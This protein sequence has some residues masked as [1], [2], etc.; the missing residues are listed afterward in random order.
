MAE[1]SEIEGFVPLPPPTSNGAA[2]AKERKKPGPRKGWKRS[3]LVSLDASDPAQH[4]QSSTPPHGT[5]VLHHSVAAC[6]TC[7]QE[8]P[9]LT[10]AVVRELV[11]SS[12]DRIEAVGSSAE[13]VAVSDIRYLAARLNGYCSLGCWR[14][15]EDAR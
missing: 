6:P 9:Q 5:A 10:L 3:A 11:Q 4:R 2:D 1:G 7:D 15:R 8:K 14:R 12:T 13:A